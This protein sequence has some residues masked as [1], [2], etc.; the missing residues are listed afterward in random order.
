MGIDSVEGL[1]QLY[2]A[3]EPKLARSVTVAQE[4]LTLLVQV[5]ILASQLLQGSAPWLAA[6]GDDAEAVILE[7]SKAISAALDENS[8]SSSRQGF[9]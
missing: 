8:C 1:S 6:L 5:Q 2:P 3:T 7:V 4:T 9:T